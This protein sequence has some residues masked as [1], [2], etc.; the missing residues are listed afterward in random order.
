MIVL[1]LDIS[2]ANV[3][4]AL[5]ESDGH[6]RHRIIKANSIH[7]SKKD[8]LYEK[9]KLVRD[10]L[11]HECAGFEIEAAVIEESL[12]S[13]G[14]RRSSAATIA[15]LNRFNGIV[16]FI[17]RDSLKIP[18]VFVN[19]LVARKRVGLKINKDSGED[20]KE[21]IFSWVRSHPV[22]HEYDWPTKVI[23]SGKRKGQKVYEVWCY[24]ISDAFVTA[25]WGCFD[26]NK[27]PPSLT[28]C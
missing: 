15:V 25:L 1:G 12:V 3:G 7:V 8:G 4:W 18:I 14:R 2:T 20:T 9:A 10:T 19:S 28:I 6:E 27:H 23:S 16:S 21:Q 11:V 5:V 17:V 13:F 26:L 24:D 22:M